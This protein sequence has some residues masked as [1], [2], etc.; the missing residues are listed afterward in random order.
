MGVVEIM[1]REMGDDLIVVTK[2]EFVQR[3]WEN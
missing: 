3:C 1:F 2:S